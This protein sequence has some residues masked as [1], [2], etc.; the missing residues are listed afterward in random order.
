MATAFS[1]PTKRVLRKMCPCCDCGVYSDD[2]LVWDCVREQF[3][4]ERC[5]SQTAEVR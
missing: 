2:L 4:H 3:V 1:T 5:P